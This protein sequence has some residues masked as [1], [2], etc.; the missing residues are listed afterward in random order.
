MASYAEIEKENNPKTTIIKYAGELHEKTGRNVIIYYSGWLTIDDEKN[1]INPLDKIGMMNMIKDLDNSK[2][3]DLILHSPGG[4]VDTT[5]SIIDYLHS[6]FG[7]DIRAIIPHMAMSGAT[8]IACTSKEII[9]GKHSSLGPVDPQIGDIS[10]Q[11]V[12]KEYELAKKEIEENPDSIPFWE[13]L[14]NK[15]PANFQFECE[16]TIDWSNDILKKN[17]KEFYV[18]RKQ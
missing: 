6:V 4:N 11:N 18:Q 17:F 8:M 1:Y 16:N 2:W 10:A 12:I 5:E 9:M 13:I 14:L 15:Y 3:L 7:E